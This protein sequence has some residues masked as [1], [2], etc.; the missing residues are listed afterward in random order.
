MAEEFEARGR[1]GRKQIAEELESMLADPFLKAILASQDRLEKQLSVPPAGE[2]ILWFIC[3]PD[4][5]EVVL[6]DLERNF[7]RRAAAR[8]VSAARRWYWW[9]VVRT[10][11]MFLV[12]IIGGVA[13]LRGLLQRLGIWTGWPCQLVAG[14][15]PR[16]ALIAK[17]HLKA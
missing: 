3:S 5:L 17:G 14:S 15:A 12:Q 8:G 13:L 10:S 11:V 16:D 4:R 2:T 6:G 1:S 7:H 9:Q